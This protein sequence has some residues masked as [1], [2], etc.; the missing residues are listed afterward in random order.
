MFV[1][2]VRMLKLIRGEASKEND[3]IMMRLKFQISQINHLTDS[4]SS[5]LAWNKLLLVIL[6]NNETRKRL[7]QKDKKIWKSPFPIHA[8]SQFPLLH[9]PCIPYNS[10]TLS[11]GSPSF[12]T[13]LSNTFIMH[14][15]NQSV[16]RVM[17]GL[18][19][20]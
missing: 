19:K 4:C 16:N 5:A 11:A 10:P 9:L 20:I 8:N 18:S 15:S 14:F 7:E 13:R 3:V 17:W 6:I 12:T 2:F 1:A